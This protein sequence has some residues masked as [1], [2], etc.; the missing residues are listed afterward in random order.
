MLN[1]LQLKK[2]ARAINVVD[3][4]DGIYHPYTVLYKENLLPFLY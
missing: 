3:E 1:T 4:S 2:P